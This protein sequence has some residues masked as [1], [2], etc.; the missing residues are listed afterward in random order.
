MLVELGAALTQRGC[1][2]P[3][4]DSKL[5]FILKDSLGGNSRTS[6]LVCCSPHHDNHEESLTTLRFAKVPHCGG[7]L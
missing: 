2:V 3:Y 7:G 6:L 1:H 5:T 4:R